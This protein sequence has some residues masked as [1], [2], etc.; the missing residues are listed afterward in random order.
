VPCVTTRIRT[1]QPV[2]VIVSPSSTEVLTG[3]KQQFS[4]MITGEGNSEVNWTVSGPGCSGSTCGSVSPEGLY[5]AP[6]R[7]PSPPQVIVTATLASDPTETATAIV[8]VVR[9]TAP[10]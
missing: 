2:A 5:A 10:R 3:G 1:V 9:P 8:T 4:A 7:L 6:P